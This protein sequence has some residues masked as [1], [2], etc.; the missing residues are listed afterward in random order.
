MEVGQGPNWSCS[1]KE[2][3]NALHCTL[4]HTVATCNSL[5]WWFKPKEEK[6]LSIYG[7]TALCW[8]FA[9][10]Q[11]LDL[12][13]QSVGLLGRGIGPL[14]GLYLHTEYKHRKN[15][16]SS[17]LRPRGHCNRR[18]TK[19][20]WTKYR[21]V[22]VWI[23]SWSSLSSFYTLLSLWR[24]ITDTTKRNPS[25]VT[26]CSWTFSFL[27][28]FILKKTFRCDIFHTVLSDFRGWLKNRPH[29]QHN[30]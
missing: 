1:A 10:F 15:A 13:T 6:N 5:M 7:S 3:K 14:Q 12:F 26:K 24:P 27:L 17:F 8:A 9:A 25:M 18:K 23:V 2:K 20:V 21:I 4:L 11:F 19:K 30:G 29:T 22:R 28:I 16:D